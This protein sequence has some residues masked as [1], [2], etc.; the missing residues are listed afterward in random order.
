[1]KI[2]FLDVD[3]VLNSAKDFY[4]IELENDKHFDLLKELVDKTGAKIVLSS[5]WRIGF[6]PT[7]HEPDRILARKLG[8]RGMFIYDFTPYLTGGRINEIHEWLKKNPV[9]K[10]VILD[11]EEVSYPNLVQTNTMVGLQKEDIE[12]ASKILA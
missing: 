6:N 12:K 4:S 1:M 8:E 3:G 5:S 2:I 9:D 7:T 10:F 11:D